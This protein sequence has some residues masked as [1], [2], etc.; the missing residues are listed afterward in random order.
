MMRLIIH[1]PSSVWKR[2]SIEN[3][4]ILRHLPRR[5]FNLDDGV[6]KVCSFWEGFLGFDLNS[7]FF[8]HYTFLQDSR[9]VTLTTNTLRMLSGMTVEPEQEKPDK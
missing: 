1:Q 5:A 9:L 4:K 8:C 6:R 3:I 7:I 2:F